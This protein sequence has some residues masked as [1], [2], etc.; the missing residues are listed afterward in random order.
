MLKAL[1][2]FMKYSSSNFS[3]RKSF[4]L[5]HRR[6]NVQTRPSGEIQQFHVDKSSG[7]Y[8][9]LHGGGAAAGVF[10]AFACTLHG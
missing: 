10:V 2:P 7:A 5:I 4:I 8:A 1:A 9:G 6:F 3:P